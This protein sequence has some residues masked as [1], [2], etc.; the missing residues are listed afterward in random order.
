M[1]LDLGSD[2]SPASR[3]IS[4]GPQAGARRI[5]PLI[6]TPF[7]ER[8]A[9]ISPDAR[10]IAYEANDSG[11]FDIYVRPYPD[12]RS[13]LWQVSVGGG[14]R[15]LWAR[16]GRELF[17]VSLTGA[18]M[19]IGVDGRSIWTSGTPTKLLNE[20]YFTVPGGNAGRTYDISPDGQRFLMIKAGGPNQPPP[21]I[22][23]VQNWLEELKR[24]VPVN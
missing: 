24:L 7:T 14:T 16:S 2:A 13:G 23:V 21:Q 18:L 17:Y 6:Q 12:V 22:V 8:N 19:R 20:G 9:V 5:V 3:D 11:Q 15:P 10:W 4:A 1:Q